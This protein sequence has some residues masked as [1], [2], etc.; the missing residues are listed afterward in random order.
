MIKTSK[1][2]RPIFRCFLVLFFR[3]DEDADLTLLFYFRKH[4]VYDVSNMNSVPTE[5]AILSFLF[6]ELKKNERTE[7]IK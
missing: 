6:F 2:L 7:K 5:L 3:N 1:Y 4:R